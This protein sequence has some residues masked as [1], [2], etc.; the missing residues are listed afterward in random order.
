MKHSNDY[1]NILGHVL[2]L[3]LFWAISGYSIGAAIETLGIDSY[4]F[5]VI[6]ASINLIIGMTLFYGI[7]SDPTAERIFFQG[8]REDEED[9]GYPQIGCL[10]IMPLSIILFGFPL[11]L[12]IFVTRFI[13]PR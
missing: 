11:W 13:F 8:P 2:V 3:A 1:L 9:V 6:F 5:G 7:T 12:I 4:S 10:W